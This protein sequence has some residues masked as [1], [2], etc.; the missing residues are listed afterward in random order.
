LPA[1]IVVGILVAS[2]PVPG[3]DAGG[4]LPGSWSGPGSLGGVAGTGV[5]AGELAAARRIPGLGGT[6]VTPGPYRP[7]AYL[8]NPNAPATNCAS[9]CTGTASGIRVNN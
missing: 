5:S 4:P 7:T 8:P 6:R 3:C 2:Q 1:L 9:T